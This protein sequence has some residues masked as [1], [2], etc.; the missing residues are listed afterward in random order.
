MICAICRGPAG[1]ELELAARPGGQAAEGEVP[2]RG[3]WRQGERVSMSGILGEAKQ[4][5]KEDWEV[6]PQDDEP[7]VLSEVD[8][9]RECREYPM[10][11]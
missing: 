9:E 8:V 7:A 4:A 11:G 1:L 2:G 3:A 6:L 10:S 5:I